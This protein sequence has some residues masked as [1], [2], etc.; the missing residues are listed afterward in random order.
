MKQ[1][2]MKWLIVLFLSLG[3]AG[4][5]LAAPLFGPEKFTR[6]AGTPDTVSRTFAACTTGATYRL[7]L[8]N[9]AEGR[10]RINSA[11]LNLNG[12][13]IVRPS[14]L[15]QRVERVEKEVSLQGENTLT[16]R[17]ASNPGGFLTIS[18]FCV[19]GCM[20]LTITSPDPG[21][22]VNRARTL[23]QGNLVNAPRETGVVLTSAGSTGES[24]ALAQVQENL[25]AGLVP[26]Q[27]G[28]NTLTATATDACG[29]RISREVVLHADS[30][31]E[32]LRLSALPVS[33]IL[34]AAGTFEVA[35]EAE[36]N[37]PNP[38][39]YAW[40][41]DGD[42]TIDQSGANLSTVT[43]QYQQPGIYFPQV[44]I[45]DAQGATFS[46]TTVVNVLSAAEMDA[47]L[48]TKWER[49][50]SR[51][52]SRDIEAAVSYF[53]DASQEKYRGMFTFLRDQL[54]EIA[55]EMNNLQLIYLKDGRAKY[56]IRGLEEGQEITYYIYFHQLSD[57]IWKIHQF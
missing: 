35:L 5:S 13:E 33:G 30:T 49:M 27:P 42:G 4:N 9:N 18:L 45:T 40:D 55:A 10:N 16:V 29:Y 56:R 48:K 20:D 17:L 44:T 43:A 39:N 54:P 52:N 32:Q 21:S 26:L 3:W 12:K 24:T 11:T 22:T 38:A 57:G 36:A 1:K 15:N 51:L 8:E 19:S 41:V 37:M 50:T 23:V 2:N 14:D 28:E 7:V 46:E 25:F 47:I 34:D 53:S 31:Q 6:E